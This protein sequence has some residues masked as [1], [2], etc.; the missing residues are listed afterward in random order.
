MRFEAELSTWLS[1]DGM[2]PPR[3]GKTHSS[4]METVREEGTEQGREPASDLKDRVQQERSSS[5]T[6]A[7]TSSGS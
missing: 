2:P 1:Y 5:E 6:Q 7:R 4:A 3:P